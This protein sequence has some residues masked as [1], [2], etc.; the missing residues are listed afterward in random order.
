[1]VDNRKLVAVAVSDELRLGL[2]VFAAG[3]LLI[4]LV[5]VFSPVSDGFGQALHAPVVLIAAV[6]LGIQALLRLITQTIGWLPGG[7]SEGHDRLRIASNLGV[8][9]L[10]TGILLSSLTRFEGTVVLAEGQ[11]FG[12]GGVGYL[13]GSVHSSW[14]AD[15]PDMKIMMTQV[16]PSFYNHGRSYWDVNALLDYRNQTTGITK[17]ASVHALFPSLLDGLLFQVSDFGYS[18]RYQ[19]SGPA[20]AV[21]DEAYVILKSFPPGAED[22]FSL[23]TSPNI[24]YVKYYP[25]GAPATEGSSPKGNGKTGPVFALRVTRVMDLVSPSRLLAPGEKA[26]LGQESISFVDAVP[27]AEVRVVRDYG[28]YLMLPG[29]CMLVGVIVV[30]LWRGR[31]A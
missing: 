15:P 19:L 1:M 29:I 5:G 12:S 23:S 26:L 30:R 10:A 7:A 31:T 16:I 9:L 22:S 6:A 20:G 25:D 28:V 17:P 13:D 4:R 11:M 14:Y 24:F 2:G 21:I 27:W 18:L 8:L 3:S